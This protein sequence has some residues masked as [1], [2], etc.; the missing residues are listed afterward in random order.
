MREVQKSYGIVVVTFFEIMH[1]RS[2][3]RPYRT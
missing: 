2:P 1:R 3:Q